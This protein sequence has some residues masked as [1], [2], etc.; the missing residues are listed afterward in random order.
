MKEKIRKI[1]KKRNIIDFTILVVITLIISIPLF[2]NKLNVYF[3]DG[4]QHIARAFGTAKSM[5]EGNHNII[6]DF[7]NDFGYSWN[8]FYG[9]LTTYGI[10]IFELIF[11][12]FIIAYK[13]FAYFLLLLSG[14]FMYKLVFK[15]FNNRNVALLS[16]VI[17]IL[18][19]YHLTDLYIRNALGEFASFVFIPLVF[20]G[21]YNLFNTTENNYYLAIGAIGL[22]LTH[23]LSTIITAIFALIYVLANL[24]EL[25]NAKILKYLLINAIF[26]ILITSFFWI[27]LLETKLS[28]NYCVYEQGFMATSESTAFRGLNISNLFITYTNDV[29][30]FEVGPCLILLAFSVM[31]LRNLQSNRK[32]YILFLIFTILSL[33]MATKYFPWKYLP[34][35]FSIIQFPWRMLEFS[36]FF[37]SI[38]CS[39]NAY[40][41]IKNFNLKDACVLILIILIYTLALNPY[42]PYSNEKLA[43]IEN[44]EQ[45]IIS[46]RENEIIAGIAK[47]EY[48]TTKANNNRF[49]IAT[50]EN[51]IY[52]LKGK[53]IIENENKTNEKLTFKVKNLEETEYE[54]PYIYYPGYEVTVDGIQIEEYE[55][56]N[57][58]LGF[59]IQEQTEATIEISYKGTKLMNISRFI[60][61]VSLMSFGIYVWKKY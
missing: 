20:L 23:N 44:I 18:A 4:I 26:I 28:A 43:D 2:N 53:A 52:V 27:P 8:L 6:T 42:I 59:K 25:G 38:V 14:I 33:F 3:D 13:V 15:I 29:F 36:S 9:P 22:I 16:S 32:E 17:Y 41:V 57:G 40:V 37:L 34:K 50:R 35:S 21:L 24:K 31:T 39:I 49:Y 45:G 19:P 10:I 46:G 58:F 7:A 54:A 30:V 11:K 55:T 60:S 5:Q 12:N 1:L 56:E 47:G 48:L 51:K 61:I